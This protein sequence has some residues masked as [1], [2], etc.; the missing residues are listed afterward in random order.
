MARLRR[1]KVNVFTFEEK[2]RVSNVFML[3]VEID[4]RLPKAAKPKARQRKVQKAKHRPTSLHPSLKASENTARLRR[5]WPIKPYSAKATKGR[6]C[7]IKCPAMSSSS[8][9]AQRDLFLRPFIYVV[10]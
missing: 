10:S 8:R 7:S 1:L 4:L 2:T 3:L 5:P 9:T 6:P